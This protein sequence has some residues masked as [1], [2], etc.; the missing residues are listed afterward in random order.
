LW[1]KNPELACYPQ[2]YIAWQVTQ[3]AATPA[4]HGGAHP[5][6][7]CNPLIF[8]SK[9]DLSTQIVRCYLLRLFKKTIKDK[10]KQASF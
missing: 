3:N 2:K 6:K 4:E 9:F 8:K 5:V 1:T 7:S 10:D